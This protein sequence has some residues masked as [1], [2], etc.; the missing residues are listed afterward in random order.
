MSLWEKWEREKLRKQGIQVE[1][2][3]D[4]DIRPT[5]VRNNYRQQAWIIAGVVFICVV[6]VIVTLTLGNLLGWRWS[7]T[8]IVRFFA[9]KAVQRE[10]VPNP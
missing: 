8:Y 3:R 5:R 6:A 7:D 2:P 1:E 4:V 10:I 9:T